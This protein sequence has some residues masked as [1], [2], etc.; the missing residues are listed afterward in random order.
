MNNWLLLLLMTLK[1][2]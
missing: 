2:N 1:M